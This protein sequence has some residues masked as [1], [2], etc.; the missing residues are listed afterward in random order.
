MIFLH[1]DMITQDSL[2]KLFV[3]LILQNEYLITQNQ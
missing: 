2:K 1:S 3:F